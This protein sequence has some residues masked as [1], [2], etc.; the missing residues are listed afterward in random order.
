VSGSDRSQKT[1]PA[2]PRRKKEARKK[3][4]IPRSSE[5]VSWVSLLAATWVL[6]G[7]VAGVGSALSGGLSQIS[8]VMVDPDPSQMVEALG[9]TLKGAALAIAPLLGLVVIVGVVTNLAQV[10]LVLTADPLKPKFN[11][12]NPITGLK[13]LFST[14]GLW[15]T[16]KSLLL[17]GVV[18][19]VAVPAIRATSEHL[20]SGGHRAVGTTVM[21]LGGEII[22]LVRLVAVLGLV[23]AAADYLYQRRRHAKDLMMTKAEVRQEQ[24]NS[25]GDPHTK[26]RI[27]SAQRGI[28][29]NRML[30]GVA[31]ANVIITNP[32]HLAIALRYVPGEGP[33]KVVAKGADHVA[34]RI[35]EEAANHGIPIVEAEP[36]ARALYKA[37]RVDDHIPFELFGGV[38]RILA[39]VQRVAGRAALGGAYVLPG[40]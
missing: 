5:V 39:F 30:A 14:Q 22:S 16:V 18:A 13:R 17:L 25:D 6:P 34:A 27:R 7:T 4:Q 35:R 12:L 31:D 40:V 19:L 33:P 20:L 36:I 26:S 10:G 28:S 23:V 1:E 3:G 9:T 15:Q 29:R 37:C 32:T 38:A 24:R 2:S 21:W 8:D 11:R